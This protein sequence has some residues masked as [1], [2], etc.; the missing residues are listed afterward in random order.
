ML[1]FTFINMQ[2]YIYLKYYFFCISFTLL[3]ITNT[4]VLESKH[5]PSSLCTISAMKKEKHPYYAPCRAICL[6]T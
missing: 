6:E 1:Q 4:S 5:S 3:L 2:E